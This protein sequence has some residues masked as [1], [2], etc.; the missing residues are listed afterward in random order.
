[1][2]SRKRA[3]R[4]GHFDVAFRWAGYSQRWLGPLF[5]QGVQ[6][7]LQPVQ[8]YSVAQVAPPAPFGA[9]LLSISPRSASRPPQI[10][11]QSRPESNDT[12][13]TIRDGV[14]LT[15]TGVQVR[16]SNGAITDYGTVTIETDNAVMWIRGNG[17]AEPSLLGGL[18]SFADRPIELYL[19]D[20]IVVRQGQRVIYAERM[21]YTF[22]ANT[23]WSCPPKC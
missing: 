3:Q 1:M 8:P 2:A 6:P 9:K 4:I 17:N 10:R 19:E 11:Y 15:I 5:S 21:Y 7:D 14:M 20:N 18:E 12:V 22:P 23:A 13:A 16:D